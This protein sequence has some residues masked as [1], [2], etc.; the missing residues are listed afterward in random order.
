[1]GKLKGILKVDQLVAKGTFLTYLGTETNSASLLVKPVEPYSGSEHHPVPRA[2]CYWVAVGHQ[3]REE[4]LEPGRWGESG[5]Y[6][7][8]QLQN[9]VVPLQ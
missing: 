2:V 6:E 7:S 3:S 8:P 4:G 1:M 5:P 9:P